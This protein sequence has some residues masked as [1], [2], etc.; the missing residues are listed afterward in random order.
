MRRWKPS[1]TTPTFSSP[2]RRSPTFRR[3]CPCSSRSC[4]PARSCVIIAEDVEGEALA[5]ILLNK[6]R[7]TF[8]CVCVKAPAFGDRRKE[9][10][11]G[12]RRPDR[13]PGRLRANYGMELKDAT[14]R[15][16][17]HVRA[18]SRSPRRTPSSST[19]PAPKEA[20]ADPC[21]AD[22]ERRYEVSTS[23]YDRE[24]LHGASG[25]V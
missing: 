13:R 18:R 2:I 17:R 20:I 8:T 22:P 9:M 10:H 1:S 14:V 23:D 25:Q 12:Y 24:K 4:R 15:Y 6:L 21:G 19:A 3:S 16:A 5:T 11:A 7:G